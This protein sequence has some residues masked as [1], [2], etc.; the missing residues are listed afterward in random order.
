M[1]KI[2]FILVATIVLL[3]CSPLS[4]DRF[5][6]PGNGVV[7]DNV[8]D[9][10]GSEKS[11]PLE[12]EY[13]F[14]DSAVV[15]YTLYYPDRKKKMESLP[16]SGRWVWPVSEYF[17]PGQ[18]KRVYVTSDSIFL[19]D[20]QWYENGNPE[21]EFS[22]SEGKK[23]RGVRYYANGNR[24]EEF[25]FVNEQRH[26]IWAEWDSLGNQTRNEEYVNGTLKRK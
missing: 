23:D 20:R 15:R 19:S 1:K 26:G 24:K 3:G 9:M 11:G 16:D 8:I 6:N 7:R 17:E 22:R 25:E 10:I 4:E 5:K 21:L 14:K 2:L 12:A 13:E 18:L